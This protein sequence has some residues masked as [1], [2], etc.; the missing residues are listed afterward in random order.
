VKDIKKYTEHRVHRNQIVPFK[1]DNELRVIMPEGVVQ[2]GK[3]MVDS[4][5]IDP[6]DPIDVMLLGLVRSS[7]ASF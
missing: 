6:D 4:G 2:P 5:D 1:I 3:T 7:N